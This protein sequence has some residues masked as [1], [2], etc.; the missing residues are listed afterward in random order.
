MEGVNSHNA[1]DDIL[2]TVNVA[3]HMSTLIAPKISEQEEFFNHDAVIK[4]REKLRENYLHLYYHTQNKMHDDELSTENSFVTEF[5]YIYEQFT[6]YKFIDEIPLI[7]YMVALFEKVVF[8]NVAN[9]TFSQQLKGYLYELR[10]F[11]EADLFQN[12]IISDQLFIMT[13]HKGKGLEFDNV[14]LYNL[15][16]GVY[17]HYRA[18]GNEVKDDAKLV[19]VALS[20][21][22]QRIFYTYTRNKSRFIERIAS[23]FKSLTAN[24]IK[25]L[26][27]MN[28]QHQSHD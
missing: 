24:H 14:C 5:K 1:M 28:R 12:G 18:Y 23:S 21:A 22:K 2:A 19:Y 15:T 11:N 13:V 8:N 25:V 3:K 6:E 16:D 10:T 20:R 27:G 9:L 7:K 4:V 26:S 17:P